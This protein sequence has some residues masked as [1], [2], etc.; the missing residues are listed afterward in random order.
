MAVR[1]DPASVLQ[2]PKIVGCLKT[3]LLGDITA[4]LTAWVIPRSGGGAR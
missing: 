2:R 4:G 1:A 3:A